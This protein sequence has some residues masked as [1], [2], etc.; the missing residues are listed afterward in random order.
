LSV[1][2]A[3]QAGVAPVLV[4]VFD[5]VP[6]V[7]VPANLLAAPV[8]G[9]VMVWGMAA[10]IAAGL[11]GGVVAVVLHWPTRL[12]IGWIAFVARRASLVPAGELGWRELALLVAAAA[13]YSAA[14]RAGVVGACRACA[15]AIA[16]A[17]VAPAVAL[18]AAPPLHVSVCDGATLW[19]RGAVVLDIDGRVDSARLLEGLRRAGVTRIDLVVARSES[20]SMQATVGALSHR[21]SVGS[22]VSPSSVREAEELVVGRLVVSI[23]PR[24]AR[25]LLVEIAEPGLARGPPV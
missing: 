3:A 17:L 5:G 6:V 18:Q 21:Y 10:G 20:T 24:A 1:T 8:A 25:G 9:P 4:S 12:M 23:T 15:A 2:I 7:A 14:R 11:L 19:R 16:I 13:G 22:V